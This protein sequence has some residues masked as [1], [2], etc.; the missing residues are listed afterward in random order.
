MDAGGHRVPGG[1]GDLG[2]GALAALRGQ[3]ASN[4]SSSYAS[5]QFP[6]AA[7]FNCLDWIKLVLLLS[8]HTQVL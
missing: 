1:P 6:V 7:P 5:S 4:P 8:G 2:D 3:E